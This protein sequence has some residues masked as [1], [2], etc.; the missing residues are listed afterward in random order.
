MIKMRAR[1]AYT[2]FYCGAI[3][4]MGFRI[5]IFSL[6]RREPPPP[7]PLWRLNYSDYRYN[8]AVSRAF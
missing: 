3:I 4:L 6:T 5:L 8:W 1:V 7:P 2:R